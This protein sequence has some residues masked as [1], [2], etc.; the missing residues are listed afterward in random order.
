MD[1][2][3]IYF[4]YYFALTYIIVF[5]YKFLKRREHSLRSLRVSPPL[6]SV[7]IGPVTQVIGHLLGPLQTV[8]GPMLGL[9]LF[10]ETRT[11][12]GLVLGLWW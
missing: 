3:L 7:L 10:I 9:G 11:E 1:Y 6:M 12:K 4:N 5:L 8:L 2:C